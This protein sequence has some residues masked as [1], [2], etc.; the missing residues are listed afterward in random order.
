MPHQHLENKRTND[1]KKHCLGRLSDE[2]HLGG[3]PPRFLRCGQV[4]TQAGATAL[5]TKST[6]ALIHSLNV[7]CITMCVVKSIYFGSVCTCAFVRFSM[8]F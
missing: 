5:K 7:F 2:G 6:L 1:F 4:P 3:Q 8:H